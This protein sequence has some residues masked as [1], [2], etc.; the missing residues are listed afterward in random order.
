MAYAY[1]F[2]YIII[3]DTGSFKEILFFFFFTLTD[4]ARLVQVLVNLVCCFNSP[5][6]D[7]SLFMI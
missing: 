4:V 3:G 2:K 7:F 6:N 5:I 1:L